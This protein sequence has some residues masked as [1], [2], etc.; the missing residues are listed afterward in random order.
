MFMSNS[1]THCILISYSCLYLLSPDLLSSRSVS[2]DRLIDHWLNA[3]EEEVSISTINH[4]FIV[5]VYDS[6]ISDG[7]M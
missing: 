5:Q 2:R 4:D 1:L 7:G 3:G 6:H